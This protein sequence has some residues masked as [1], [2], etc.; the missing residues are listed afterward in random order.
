M[1]LRRRQHPL[2]HATD[3]VTDVRHA[4]VAHLHGIFVKYLVESASLREMFA[5]Q[6]QELRG[7]ICFNTFGIR[8][9]KPGDVTLTVALL[10]DFL[11]CFLKKFQTTDGADGEDSK[12]YTGLSEPPFKARFTNHQTSMKHQK[13][14]NSTEL[15]KRVWQLRESGKEPQVT[16]RVV[17]KSRAYLTTSKTC[18]LCTAEKYRIITSD[19]SKTLNKKSELVSKCRHRNN[20][21]LSNY[22][23]IT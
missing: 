19:Q 10:L 6:L 2:V 11:A 20:F 4:R 8:W 12:I 5:D 23:A 14:K 21:L 7:N 22:T 16:W 17:E 13:Y 3:N 15:S 1:V 18:N 9:V